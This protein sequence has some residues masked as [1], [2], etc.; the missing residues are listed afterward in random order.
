MA[1]QPTSVR[2]PD[3]T[4]RQLNHLIA[5]T[6]MTQS[7]LIST[8]IDRMYQ[9]ETQTMSQKYATDAATVD[10]IANSVIENGRVEG[11]GDA[12]LESLRGEVEFEATEQGFSD[13]EAAEIAEAAVSRYQ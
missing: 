2:F 8:A 11:E 6:G 1:K 13:D 7:E 5:Q 3:L 10:R 4:I 12:W 9:Q